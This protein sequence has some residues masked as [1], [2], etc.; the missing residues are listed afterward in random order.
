MND[1]Q[2]A[3]FGG[4]MGWWILVI[5]LFVL[6]KGG[7][8]IQHVGLYTTGIGLAIVLFAGATR[9]LERR[10]MGGG[11]CG[12][13]LLMLLIIVVMLSMAGGLLVVGGGL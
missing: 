3:D 10:V 12:L 5:G 4:L 2:G 9:P 11:F 6:A 7:D 8:E 1:T 13:G